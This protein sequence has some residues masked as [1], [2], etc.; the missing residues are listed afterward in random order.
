VNM[1]VRR[2]TAGA[3]RESGFTLVEALVALVILAIG[4]L[5]IA[6]LYIEGLRASRAALIRTEAVTLAADLA[7]RI[8]INRD[9]G[10]S[11]AG[12]AATAPN[13]NC[14]PGGA[15]CDPADLAA[16]DLRVWLDAIAAALPGGT[17]TVVRTDPVTGDE[18]FLYT[19][20][21]NWTE[22]G[23]GALSYTLR[24]ET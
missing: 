22:A 6:A 24:V 15:G 7:D 3:P 13:A 23:Q 5:G 21:V 16:H 11:Y 2:T 1:P 20:T 9:G 8:R 17:G 14:L 19:I 4:M 10:A 18:I 12:T